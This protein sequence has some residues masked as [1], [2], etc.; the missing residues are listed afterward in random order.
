MDAQDEARFRDFAV[1]RWHTL[2]RTAFLLSGDRDGA[3]RLLAGALARCH[4]AWGEVERTDTPETWVRREMVRELTGRR[5]RRAG[6]VPAEPGQTFAGVPDEPDEEAARRE[7]LWQALLALP[8]RLRAVLVLRRYEQLSE[9]GTAQL[10][11]CSEAAVRRHE[12]HALRLLRELVDPP[13][14]APAREAEQSPDARAPEAGSEA[15]AAPARPHVPP[16]S[17]A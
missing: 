3:E 11:G 16:R 2:L 10:V 9:A 8:P 17:A 12:A 5:R 15:S 1:G 13:A 6:P 14:D 7:A 4:G